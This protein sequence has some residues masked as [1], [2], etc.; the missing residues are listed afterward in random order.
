MLT[1]KKILLEK[2]IKIY[3]NGKEIQQSWNNF[4][5]KEDA[6]KYISY[7]EIAN[8]NVL[9]DDIQIR[10]IEIRIYSVEYHLS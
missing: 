6:L 7:G 4:K 9:I 2:E 10:E 5:T 1:S 3:V 8:C